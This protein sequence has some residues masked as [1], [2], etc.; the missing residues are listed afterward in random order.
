MAH[1]RDERRHEPV[2][3]ETSA[4]TMA[5]MKVALGVLALAALA[6]FLLQNLQE[7][8][9]HFLWF[10]WSTRLIWAL[11]ASAAVGTL[12]TLLIS[13]LGRRRRQP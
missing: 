13:T 8:Q 6:T 9:V 4:G 11:L 5:R 2:E 10:D 12:A 1:A 7:V 3:G